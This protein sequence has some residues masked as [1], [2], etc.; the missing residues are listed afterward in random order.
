MQNK[1]RWQASRLFI[2]NNLMVREID[3]TWN[4]IYDSILV[5]Y[6]KLRSLGFVWINGEIKIIEG[7]RQ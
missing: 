7:D 2:C 3:A 1:K 5:M 6:Q 4:P